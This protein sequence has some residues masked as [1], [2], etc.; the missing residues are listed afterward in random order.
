MSCPRG[1]V[2]AAREGGRRAHERLGQQVRDHEVEAA[3]H[4]VR[5]GCSE[6]DACNAVHRAVGAR[7]RQDRGVG[8][9]GEHAP[10]PEP[11][12]RDGEDAGP[13]ADV[14]RGADVVP[15]DGLL[16]RL[17]AAAR[18]GVLAGAERHPGVDDDD[19]AA[20]GGRHV[21]RWCDHQPPSDRDRTMVA[22]R[23]SRPVD[24]GDRCRREGG[25]PESRI[26]VAEAGEV[27]GERG[28]DAVVLAGRHG[29]LDTRALGAVF[30]DHAR[31]AALDEEVRD[32]V[33]GF[34]RN[35]DA[36][37]DPL[38]RVAHPAGF[39][40]WIGRVNFA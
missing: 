21:P 24:R 32:R 11:G 27:A 29:R 18:G 6:R 16:D 36:Y 14:E 35:L 38:R 30:G 5:R 25:V 22:A 15:L 3:A 20:P 9:D 8:V 17:E 31:G 33:G 37:R 1:P 39:G 10:D 28:G 26:E 12:E 13:R 19:L 2:R 7:D 4:A 40:V 23:V 34:V